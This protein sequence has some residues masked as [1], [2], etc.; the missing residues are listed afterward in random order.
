MARFINDDVKLRKGGRKATKIT[1]DELKKQIVKFYNKHCLEDGDE[2]C[3]MENLSLYDIFENE[4]IDKD[5]KFYLYWED[6]YDSISDISTFGNADDIG[7][8]LIGFHTLDNGFTFL[9]VGGCADWGLRS[10][11]ILY[12]DGKTIRCYTPSYGNLINLD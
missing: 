3:T 6:Y 2:E 11:T 8:S 1:I 9:G 7:E 4:N 10:F 12:Y 5:R